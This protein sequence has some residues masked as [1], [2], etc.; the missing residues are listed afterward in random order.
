METIELH[1]DFKEFLKYLNSQK[2]EYLLIGGYA[3]GYHGYP[4][5]TGDIDIWIAIS[6]ENACKILIVLQEFGMPVDIQKKELFLDKDKI[7][8]MGVPPVRIEILTGI[9]GRDFQDCYS[10]R[11]QIEVDG[12]KINI[13]SLSDLKINKK[14]SGR[15]KDL[16]DL[17]HLP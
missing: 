15:H 1:P 3:V 4:R 6:E 7:I 2:V 11:E 5:A 17:V 13:I 10:R 14:N 9:S 16:E 8:R 12:I